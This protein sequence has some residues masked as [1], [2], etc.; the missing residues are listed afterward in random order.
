MKIV[1]SLNQYLFIFTYC[2]LQGELQLLEVVQDALPSPRTRPLL[3]FTVPT[4]QLPGRPMGRGGTND[5]FEVLGNPLWLLKNAGASGGE[6]REY[7]ALV[8]MQRLG[9]TTVSPSLVEFIDVDLPENN[10]TMIMMKRVL[11]GID[12]KTIVGYQRDLKNYINPNKEFP[13]PNARHASFIKDET[14]QQLLWGFTRIAS[15]KKDFS[16]YQ[17][18]LDSEGTVFYND[19]TGELPYKDSSST[20]VII[21]ATIDTWEYANLPVGRGMSWMKFKQLKAALALYRKQRFLKAAQDRTARPPSF[22]IIDYSAIDWHGISIYCA[23]E[24][25]NKVSI[26]GW[27]WGK[28]KDKYYYI[29]AESFPNPRMVLGSSH[30]DQST[31]FADEDEV[32]DFLR[33]LG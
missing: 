32:D 8:E 15:S 23:F 5:V 19:P 9:L 30:Y 20:R 7:N 17:F 11:N 29:P 4:I 24:S 12:S 14:I 28:Y 27:K 16:D 25:T 6:S 10:L 21:Q 22:C 1:L 18:M 3:D 26:P 13:F 31:V 33:S 2:A